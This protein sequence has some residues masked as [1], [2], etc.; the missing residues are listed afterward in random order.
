ML[1]KQKIKASSSTK[2]WT[3]WGKKAPVNTTEDVEEAEDKEPAAEQRAMQL[4]KRKLR[5]I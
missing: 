1:R 2:G 3:K 4:Q 5:D